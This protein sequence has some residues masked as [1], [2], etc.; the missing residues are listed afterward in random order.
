MPGDE[1]AL[2]IINRIYAQAARAHGDD[3]LKVAGAVEALVEALAPDERLAVRAAFQRIAS[4][5]A[6][7][8]PATDTRH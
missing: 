3:P 5:A 4:F 2:E 8:W 1:S 6:T 7:Q